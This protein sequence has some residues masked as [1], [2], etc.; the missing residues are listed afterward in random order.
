MAAAEL[1]LTL[2]V[3]PARDA[4]A[5]VLTEHGFDVTS[6]P[7]ALD[8]SAPSVGAAVVVAVSAANAM[9]VAPRARVEATNRAVSLRI[10]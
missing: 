6:S 10:I 4:V 9:L 2:P 8:V 5:A 3:D 7:D 1:R